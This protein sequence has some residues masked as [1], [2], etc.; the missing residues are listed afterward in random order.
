MKKYFVIIPIFIL[1]VFLS[2][3]GLKLFLS[4]NVIKVLKTVEVKR[5]D[6]RG[7]LVE[8]GIVKFKVGSQV[9][10]GARATGEISEMLVAV[11][12]HVK[13][14]DTIAVI[15]DREILTMMDQT[16]AAVASKRHK[17]QQVNETYPQLIKEAEANF[18]YAKLDF[19]R[20]LKLIDQE[21]TTRVAVERAKTAYESASAVLERVKEEYNTEQK[22]V[23]SEIK[24]LLQV[25]EQQKIKLSYAKIVAPIGGVVSEVTAQVGETIVTGLQVANLVTI[26]D[27]L[28]LEIWIYVDE[29]EIGTVKT[30]QSVEFQVDTYP[31]KIFTGNI[32][33]INQQPVI[34]DNITYYLAIVNI[35][36][37]VAELL[38]PEMTVYVR[39]IYA[40]KQGVLTLA[41]SAIKF[42][43]GREV[44]YMMLGKK[45]VEKIYFKIGLRGEEKSEILSDILPGDIFATELLISK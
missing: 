24:E 1:L 32:N 31:D 36:K 41:N 7:V 2:F 21:Y 18:E 42:E 39:I 34:K 26:I 17:L 20:E 8:A 44:G 13:K 35:T 25:M 19:K 11:G 23:N 12:S 9:K 43:A 22:I 30:G 6:I 37:N 28:G 45:K 40:E 5:S 38:R 14:G 16:G 33:K 27:P 15:D 3:F 29:T 4:D 10:V